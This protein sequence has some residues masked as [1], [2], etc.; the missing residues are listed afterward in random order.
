ME[1]KDLSYIDK[2]LAEIRGRM[3]AA[4]ARSPYG[5]KPQLLV[6]S[7]YATAEEI[8]YAISRGV[9][10]FGENRVSSLLEKYDMID[11]E[12]AEIH[13]IGSLQTNKVKS[14]IGKVS[15]IHS[16]DSVRLAEAIEKHSAAA[17]VTTAVLAEINIGREPQKGGIMPEDAAAFAEKISQFPHVELRGMMTMAPNCENVEEYRKYFRET[18]HIFIDIFQKKLHN[19]SSCANSPILSMGMSGSYEPAIEE[20]ADIVRIGRAVFKKDDQ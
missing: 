6:A 3:E 16:L 4:A 15:L 19:I 8:N 10:L 20:G 13:F 9:R 7:K 1:N 2:N 14:V 12:K 5:N 18:Y 11:R 17:G